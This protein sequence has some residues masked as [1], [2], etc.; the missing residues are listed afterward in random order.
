[1]DK[2]QW[3]VGNHISALCMLK[4]HC[5]YLKEFSPP[6]YPC[7]MNHYRLGVYDVISGLKNGFV[8]DAYLIHI[9]IKYHQIWVWWLF[10]VSV[11]SRI[12]P[13]DKFSKPISTNLLCHTVWTKIPTAASLSSFYFYFRI[14]IVITMVCP[15]P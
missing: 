6:V 14:L 1:M 10:E 11:L 7:R 9:F 5:F 2:K 13:R 4:S 15:L 8:L 12:L 3:T